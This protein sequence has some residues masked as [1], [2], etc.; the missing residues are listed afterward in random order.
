MQIREDEF[1]YAQEGFIRLQE[2]DKAI[3][4]VTRQL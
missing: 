4:V 1:G 2:L 3:E